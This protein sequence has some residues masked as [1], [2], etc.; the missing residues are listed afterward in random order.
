MIPAK[1]R[2]VTRVTKQEPRRRGSR[3]ICVML[4]VIA[5]TFANG[6]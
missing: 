2:Q 3:N 4:A 1:I 5:Q 6:G